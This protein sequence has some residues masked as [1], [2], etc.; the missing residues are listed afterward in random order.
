MNPL[1]PNTLCICISLMLPG[2]ILISYV[3]SP[4]MVD[5]LAETIDGELDFDYAF[6][7]LMWFYFAWNALGTLL[8]TIFMRHPGVPPTHCTQKRLLRNFKLFNTA[9]QVRHRRPPNQY[10]HNFES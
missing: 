2:G 7:V 6:K 1:P 3:I 9:W 4:I 5:A 10:K 8:V